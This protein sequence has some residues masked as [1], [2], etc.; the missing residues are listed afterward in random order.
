MASIRPLP[1]DSSV[2]GFAAA[3]FA[4]RTTLERQLEGQ[5][6]CEEEEGEGEMRSTSAQSPQVASL[7]RFAAKVID[8]PLLM[9]KL[10]R[11]VYEL[12]QADLQ[13]QRE[14]NGYYGRR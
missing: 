5:C 3:T 2:A 11:R 1:L 7:N 13:Q 6:V 8:H 12:L 4:A 9:D 14:R 10:G